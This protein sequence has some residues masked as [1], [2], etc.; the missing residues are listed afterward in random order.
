MKPINLILAFLVFA[1][2]SIIISYWIGLVHLNPALIIVVSAFIA[3]Y[4]YKKYISKIELEIPPIVWL[5]GILVMAMSAYP[6]LLLTQFY[7]ASSDGLHTVFLRII[8]EKIPATFAP[9]SDLKV[10]YAIGYHLFVNNFAEI[11]PLFPDYLWLWLFGIIFAGLQVIF[12]YLFVK[13]LT[14]NENAALLSAFLFVGTKTLFQNVLFGLYP[15]V[16]ATLLFF[17]FAILFLRKN[18]LSYL[19]FPVVFLLHPG[20]SFN[21]M[22]FMVLFVLFFREHLKE[23]LKHLPFLLLAL[24]VILNDYIVLIISLLNDSSNFSFSIIEFLKSFAPLF[25]WVGF[26]PALLAII[27]IV[28]VFRERQFSKINLFLICSLIISILLYGYFAVSQGLLF[29]KIV[30]IISFLAIILASVVLVSEIKIGRIYLFDFFQENKIKILGVI[31]VVSLFFFFSSGYLNSLREGNKISKE[32]AQFAFAFKN[33]DSSRD[34]VLILSEG[35]TK[36]AEL[37]DKIPFNAKRHWFLPYGEQ[38]SV[39][40]EAFA[41]LTAKDILWNRIVYTNCS[42]CI[43]ELDVKYIVVNKDFAN[44]KQLKLNKQRVFSFGNFE[45]FAQE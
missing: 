1:A 42:S 8:N 26:V 34:K 23:F 6:L 36:I 5:L 22:F 7:P 20:A 10:S 29:G 44:L 41:D 14:Q 4:F 39:L 9:Y 27:A 2:I 3:F 12:F 38:Q 37:A 45:V 11:I 35:N 16:L 25:L 17:V 43:D 13:Q 18:K 40:D 33:F 31:L 19:F 30:E 24:P 15:W 21:M 32:E 28:L